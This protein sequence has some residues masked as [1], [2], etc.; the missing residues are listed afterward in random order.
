[1]D[2]GNALGV[3]G[4]GYTP[5]QNSEAFDFFDNLV[6]E[7]EACYQSAGA[8]GLGERI[9]ILAKLP[10]DIVIGKEDLINNY[11]L[12]YNSFD[13][14]SGITALITPIRVVCNNTLTAALKEAKN[15]VV[16]RHT[17]N[18]V[19]R[20]KQAH[21]VLGLSNKYRV[22]LEASLNAL[23][24]KQVN[25]K[26]VMDFLSGVYDYVDPETKML[27]AAGKKNKEA[28]MEI[29]E[30][31][32]GGQDMPTCRGTMYGLY[33]AFTFYYDNVIDY[34]TQDNKAQ[35]LWFGNSAAMRQWAFDKATSLV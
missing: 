33:N 29:F 2:N 18:V 17:R 26:L 19:D 30:S 6:N 13:G 14:S 4:K 25:K 32:V 16:I 24:S 1:M 12:V 11:V 31:N 7:N 21:T 15:K 35:S 5:V 3:V 22:E 34:K 10:T 27:K 28:I 20:L 8:L 9:W 23:A